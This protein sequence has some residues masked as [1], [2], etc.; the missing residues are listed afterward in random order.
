M[1]V[2]HEIWVGAL[3]IDPGNSERVPSH[4]LKVLSESRE[5]VPDVQ[6]VGIDR[7][8]GT[9]VVYSMARAE[10][11]ELHA[12]I[13]VVYPSGHEE[14]LDVVEWVMRGAI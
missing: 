3:M 4:E 8:A 5:E 10:P 1:R 9:A 2:V 12:R 11:R 14:R 6:G 7:D 13:L